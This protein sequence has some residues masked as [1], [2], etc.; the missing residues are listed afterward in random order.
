MKASTS[1]KAMILAALMAGVS[2][3]QTERSVGNSAPFIRRKEKHKSPE[4]IKRAM[5]K[6]E[7]KRNRRAANHAK[8]IENSYRGEWVPHPAHSKPTYKEIRQQEK[9]HA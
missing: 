9:S 3:Q 8:S 2:A 5:E 6:Q 1:Q 7:R 4:Y